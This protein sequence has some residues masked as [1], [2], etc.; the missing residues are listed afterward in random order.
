MN[1]GKI[2]IIV[3]LMVFI[4]VLYIFAAS[5]SNKLKVAAVFGD[6]MV[7]QRDMPVAVFGDAGKGEEITVEMAG[8]TATAKAGKDGSW[9]AELQPLKAGGPYEMT[10]KGKNDTVVIK[11]VLVGDVWF[12]SG[13]S[14]MEW[15]LMHATDGMEELKNFKTNPNIRLFLQEQIAKPK[16]AKD[17][18]GAWTVCDAEN[19]G[20]FSA[21]AYFFGSDLQKELN[22]PIGLIDSSWGG[23][24]IEIWMDE[25]LLKGN[26]ITQPIVDRWKANPVFDWKNWNYGKGMNYKIEVKDIQFIS[27]PGKEQPAYVKVYQSAQGT[28]GGTWTTWAKPGSTADFKSTGKTG[29]LSG[30]MGFNAWAGAGTVLNNGQEVDLSAYDKII[31]KVRGIGKFS[32]SLDQNTITDFDYY[33]SPDYDA[34][35]SWKDISIPMTAFKQGGWGVAK[36]FTQNAIKQFQFNIKSAT[37][38]LPSSLYNGMVAPFERFKIKGVIWYQGETNADRAVQYSMLLPEM[39]SSWRKAWLEG[40]FPFIIVQLPNYMARKTQPS[41]SAW[42]ELRDAQ[43]VALGLSNTAVVSTIDIGDANDIHPRVKKPVAG[44][45]ANA[46]MVMAYGKQGP[47]TGPVY[48]SMSIDKN[49]IIITFTNTGSGLTAKDGDLKGFAIAGDDRQFKWAKAEIKDNTVVVWSDDIKDPK[50]VRY[51]WAD[52]PECN[53]Y[54]KE[55]LAASPFRT[56]TWPGVTD[57]KR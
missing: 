30:I 33:S 4:F 26:P 31:F 50:A 6:H 18:G 49:K 20:N 23:T 36:P 11:D 14:N 45:L 32:V 12:C 44:R 7:L 15:Q 34:E 13:Q 1:T 21:V 22:V 8:Q 48:K 51:A 57:D 39:I 37:V 43:L 40:D 10:I 2:M 46:A 55:G 9:T 16:P 38:E 5:Q 47:A 53:L 27:S 25:S 54:N 56:D 19:A 17:A 28:F 24:P 29:D 52:N 42:A 3:F 41:E 35:K